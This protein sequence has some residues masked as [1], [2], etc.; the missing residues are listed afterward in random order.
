[1]ELGQ[2]REN[3]ME[4]YGDE[5]SLGSSRLQEDFLSDLKDN[6]KISPNAF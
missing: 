2:D 1:M 5:G 3:F 6:D 4:I